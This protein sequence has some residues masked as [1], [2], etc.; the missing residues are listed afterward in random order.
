MFLITGGNNPRQ[1]YVR[2]NGN[3]RQIGQSLGILIN[4]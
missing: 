4:P 2:T 1:F 3:F